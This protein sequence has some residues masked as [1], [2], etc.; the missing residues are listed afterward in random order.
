LNQPRAE[1]LEVGGQL[2]TVRQS[3][4]TS[5]ATLVQFIHNHSRSPSRVFSLQPQGGKTYDG[6]EHAQ[7]TLRWRTGL[8]WLQHCHPCAHKGETV[9]PD[10]LPFPT[11]GLGDL[12]IGLALSVLL[13]E[14]LPFLECGGS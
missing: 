11:A 12:T 4:A 7:Q 6:M 8:L 10:R 5:A 9:F 14:T 1:L 2:R 13:D 3:L